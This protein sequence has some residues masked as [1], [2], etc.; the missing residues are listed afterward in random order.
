MQ[1]NIGLC[2]NQSGER[3]VFI[4]APDAKLLEFQTTLWGRA[5]QWSMKFV[6]TD[7]DKTLDEVKTGFIT[8]FQMPNS[9]QQN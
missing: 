3:R 6:Q 4:T 9:E 5:F 1:N 8:K 2:V 7:A